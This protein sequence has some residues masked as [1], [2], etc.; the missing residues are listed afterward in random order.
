MNKLSFL[1]W[2]SRH[3]EDHE[4]LV[5]L[6]IKHSLDVICLA[7]SGFDPVSTTDALSMRTG[8]QF[9]MCPVTGKK[10]QLFACPNVGL[11]EVYGAVDN[12]RISV[13]EFTFS[14]EKHLLG[15]V[16]FP[17]KVNWSNSAADLW[18][19]DLVPQ[20][21]VTPF[22]IMSAQATALNS[23]MKGLVSAEV[24][25]L[26]VDDNADPRLLLRF[27]IFSIPQTR[28][29]KLFEAAHRLDFSYP[30][31]LHDTIGSIV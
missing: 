14:N 5:E 31:V 1:F 4:I 22:E 26:A 27:E 11:K 23:R 15:I 30:V 19:S 28:R 13:Q 3:L 10:L 18:P 8:K 29:V 16:H 24:K 12:G 9:S 25:S 21:L 2:N 17:S 20:E 6:A 7:E